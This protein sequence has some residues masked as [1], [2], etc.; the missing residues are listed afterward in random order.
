MESYNLSYS[1]HVTRFIEKLKEEVPE[2]IDHTVGRKKY[3]LEKKLD[4]EVNKLLVPETLLAMMEKVTH[5]VRIKLKETK[6]E[7]NGVF[8]SESEA[9]AVP[10]ELLILINLLVCGSADISDVGFSLPVKTISQ[11]V[12][13]NHKK[14][15]SRNSTIGCHRHSSEKETP[16]VQYLGLKMYATV[17]SR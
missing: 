7:F 16:F 12:V 17:R 13:F 11:L 1:P 6:N 3:I 2:L 8:D 10:T 5:Q 14:V 9:N 4:K 15:T